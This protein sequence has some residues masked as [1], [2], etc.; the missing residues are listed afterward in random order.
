MWVKEFQNLDE[1][2]KFIVDNLYYDE[3]KG[4]T[5]LKLFSGMDIADAPS[6]AGDPD[7]QDIES[8]P[9]QITEYVAL[10]DHPEKGKKDFN[11]ITLRLIAYNKAPLKSILLHTVY[12]DTGEYAKVHRDFVVSLLK[13][14]LEKFD[15]PLKKSLGVGKS[16]LKYQVG[17][18]ELYIWQKF[19]GLRIQIKNKSTKV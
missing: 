15:K 2:R 14:I 12:F 19:D 5:F 1:L 18:S 6:I 16:M 3:E 4:Y 11:K 17:Y 8:S 9:Q 13:S 7:Y 10:I